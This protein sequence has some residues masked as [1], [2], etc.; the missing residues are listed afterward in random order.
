MLGLGLP[1][2]LAAIVMGV[3][4]SSA[5]AARS[6]NIVS[7]GEPPASV[8]A[9]THY[10]KTIQEAV[11]AS[12]KGSWVL[13][14]PG[15]YK[16]EVWVGSAQAGIHIR[17]MNRNS[18]ILDGEHKA[19]KGGAN[20]IEIYKANNVSVENLTVRNFDRSALNEEG[21]PELNI[22]GEG[23]NEIWWNGGADSGE[24]GA[25]RWQGRYLTAY[26]DSLYGGYGIFTNNMVNGSW[27]HIYAS[28]FND[29]GMY[30]GACRN[31]KARI[32][33]AVME[34]NAL[35]YSGSNSGGKL[36]IEDS[37]FRNNSAGIAPNS[38]NP[39]DG[40]PPQ[41]GACNSGGNRSATPKFPS[42]EIARCTI[43]RGNTV[44]DNN[45]LSTPANTSA[46]K[47]P[48]GVGVELPGVYGDL[49]EGN[50]ITGNVNDGVLGFE[51]PNP[52]PPEEDTIAFQFAGNRISDNRLSN[53]G[54]SGAGFAEEVAI[55]GGLFGQQESTNNCLSGNTYG[56]DA[57]FPANIEGE[58]G[59]QNH[60]TPN[61]GGGPEFVEYLVQLQEESFARTPVDQPAP[62]PQPT[63]P[64]PCQEVPYN[65][66]C[67]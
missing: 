12:T 37:V 43:F 23:G 59:C 50:T 24:I 51:Y 61:A 52:F 31:C 48:W 49:V 33:D 15:V 28:G 66:L 63:M 27:E 14:E 55:E 10:F 18:V 62:G 26:D 44:E 2:P 13:I 39:G 20:G 1:G 67:Q 5:L 30:L 34:D 11:N 7:Q 58:W 40:P 21:E 9:N 22:D 3:C 45:N 36:L 47:A 38:E 25:K 6:V 16:E 8:P 35:G 29:S 65:P 64:N 4:A 57:T 46:A 17:G 60:T 53:N 32:F 56:V 42:T 54:T 19:V 41:D